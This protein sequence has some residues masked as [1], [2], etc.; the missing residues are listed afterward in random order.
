MKRSE[1]QSAAPSCSPSV[2]EFLAVENRELRIAGCKLAEAALHVAREYDGVHRL[3]LAVAEW[4]KA[5]ADEGGRGRANPKVRGGA[6]TG[7]VVKQE[8]KTY[9]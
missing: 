5:V 8:E 9:A 1:M 6:Q 4:A 7:D 2:E 3:M